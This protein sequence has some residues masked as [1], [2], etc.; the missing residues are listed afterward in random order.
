[1]IKEHIYGLDLID[2]LKALYGND[3]IN[4][5]K[6]RRKL[7][8]KLSQNNIPFMIKAIIQ[9]PMPVNQ[10][11][12]IE[13]LDWVKKC[14]DDISKNGMIVIEKVKDFVVKYHLNKGE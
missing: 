12:Y 9:N 7:W 14:E 3:Y 13:W 8:E 11:Y 2:D 6:E 4:I 10:K 1:M 5:D